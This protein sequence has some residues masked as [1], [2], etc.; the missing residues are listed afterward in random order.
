MW[1]AVALLA[2]LLIFAARSRAAA[3]AAVALASGV[4]EKNWGRL[5]DIYSAL[6][7]A[8]RNRIKAMILRE[9]MGDPGA[10]GQAGERGLMQLTSGA[11][12][13]V[14]RSFGL[15][16]S[17]QQMFEPEPNIQTGS[18]YLKLMLRRFGNLDLA[19]QAYNAGPGALEADPSAGFSYLE[20][21]KEIESTL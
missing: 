17:W 18:L 16:F 3:P 5:V 1:P 14:C 8:P 21:V 6:A 11:L 12:A 13:D 9:S 20:A 4:V 7:G 15:T 19:T 2:L 10:Q